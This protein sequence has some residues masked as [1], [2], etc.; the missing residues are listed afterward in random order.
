[1]SMKRFLLIA[2][3]GYYPDYGTGD[4][5]GCFET[6]EEAESQITKEYQIEYFK[7]GPRKGKEKARRE[8]RSVLKN[9]RKSE[10][11]WYEIVDLNDWV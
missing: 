4:W 8:I 5:V 7:S 3:D 9:G 10:F 6:K 1:M 2:G 11:D